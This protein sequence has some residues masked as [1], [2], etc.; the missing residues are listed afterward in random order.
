MSIAIGAF[1]AALTAT[2]GTDGYLTFTAN[3]GFYPGARA[4][5]NKAD[6]TLPQRVL[7]TD[8][9]GATKVGVR[10]IPEESLGRDD[11]KVRSGA[12]RPG[13][14]GRSDASAYATSDVLSQDAQVVDVIQPAFLPLPTIAH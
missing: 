9:S 11:P 1:A 12:V 4:W 10:F 14:Y 7:L 8:L 5:L 3:A 2:G 6:G 13:S